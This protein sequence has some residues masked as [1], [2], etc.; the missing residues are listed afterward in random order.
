[1]EDFLYYIVLSNGLRVAFTNTTEDVWVVASKVFE[2]NNYR[3]NE[4]VYN[5]SHIIC[6]ERG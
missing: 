3:I 4:T 2:N 6:V 1:M 5:T